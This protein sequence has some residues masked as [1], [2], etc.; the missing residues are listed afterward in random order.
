MSVYADVGV[1]KLDP[2]PLTKVL[3]VSSPHQVVNTYQMKARIHAVSHMLPAG[4][5]VTRGAEDVK[6]TMGRDVNC[7]MLMHELSRQGFVAYYLPSV[8]PT[9]KLLVP[10]SHSGGCEYVLETILTDNKDLIGRDEIDIR[11][12]TYG[13]SFNTMILGIPS[14][15]R[16][17]MIN[18]FITTGNGRVEFYDCLSIRICDYC[19]SYGHTVKNCGGAPMCGRCCQRHLTNLCPYRSQRG[20]WRCAGC[21]GLGH[22]V[23]YY[24]CPRMQKIMYEQ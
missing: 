9:I 5:V 13:R 8:C 22:S 17:R 14:K 10:T 16:E 23:Y 24:N 11:G 4:A 18:P 2:Y 15:L 12:L 19:S 20:S 1:I 6:V 3:A 21:K 7:D